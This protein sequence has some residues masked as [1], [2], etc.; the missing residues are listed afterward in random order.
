VYS[1]AP[2]RSEPATVGCREDLSAEESYEL[3]CALRCFNAGTAMSGGE[4]GRQA[5]T[6][7]SGRH[8]AAQVDDLLASAPEIS[9]RW[10]WLG[11]QSD[12]ALT[13]AA[14]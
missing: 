9:G 13:I 11:E 14:A 12:I 6:S 4:L 8:Y 1:G 10:H 7:R 5:D 2:G 3:D